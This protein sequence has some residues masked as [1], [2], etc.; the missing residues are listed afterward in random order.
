MLYYVAW[1]L[2]QPWKLFLKVEGLENIPKKTCKMIVI[3]SH[4]GELDPWRIGIYLPFRSVVH[5]FAKEEFFSVR[6]AAREFN[7]FLAPFASLI[8]RN[9]QAIPVDK[10][11]E[12]APINRSAIKV[13]MQLLKK[14]KILGIFPRAK[15][16]E[17]IY[18]NSN[19]IGLAI[20]TNALILPVN[21]QG[22]R[23][24]FGETFYMWSCKREECLEKAQ[25]IM[26]NIEAM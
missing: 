13:A 1:L 21:V 3:A 8:V 14:N 17:R 7:W 4:N 24:V 11:N 22:R 10:N 9:S 12:S 2:L 20:K 16:G 6:K 25:E 5:W 18:V 26:K 19:F 23:I 15:I